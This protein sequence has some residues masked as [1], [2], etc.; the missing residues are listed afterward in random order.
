MSCYVLSLIAV[1][2]SIKVYFSFSNCIQI[3]LMFYPI[4]NRLPCLPSS[5]T[6]GKEDRLSCLVREKYIS[7]RFVKNKIKD[8][9]IKQTMIRVSV[10]LLCPRRKNSSDSDRTHLSQKKQKKLSWR[11]IN[12][13][14]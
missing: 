2:Y 12:S 6:K 4:K 10:R 7:I 14:N 13:R 8:C 1:F 5:F 9:S 3:S 11:K